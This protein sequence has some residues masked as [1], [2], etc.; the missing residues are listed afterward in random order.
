MYRLNII[1]VNNIVLSISLNITDV[2]ISDIYS[3]PSCASTISIKMFI[4][5]VCVHIVR[6]FVQIMSPCDVSQIRK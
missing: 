6:F 1:D 3:L 4:D 2:Q 5:F